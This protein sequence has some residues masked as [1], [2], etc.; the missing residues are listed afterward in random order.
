MVEVEV[1]QEV[2]EEVEARVGRGCAAPPTSRH[3]TSLHATPFHSSR[4]FPP[5]D[6]D[7]EYSLFR[8]AMSA[9]ARVGTVA[10]PA[11]K[12]VARAFLKLG[13]WRWALADD[14]DDATLADVLG[15]FR[16]ATDACRQWAKAWHHWALFNAAAME[17]YT[18]ISPAAATRHVAPAI[19][20]FFRSIALGGSAPQKRKGGPLQDILRL[21]TLWFNHGAA[22]EVEAALMEGFGHV[23]IDTWLAVI[24]QIVARI[25]SNSP[26]V[27]ALIHQLLVRIGRQHPQALLYP[28]L[29]ACKSQSTSRRSAA[30]VVLD[31]LR[32]H[33]ALLVEQAQVVSLE[34]IRVAILWHEAWHEAL[35]EASQLYFGEQNVDGMLRVLAPLHHIIERLG[36]ETLHEISFVQA[37]GRELQ[38]AN[39]WCQKYRETGREEELNQAW[40]LYYHV[41]KRINKQLPTLTTLELQYVSPRLLNAQG[42]ELCVPGNYMPGVPGGSVTI[43]AFAPTMHVIT[44][45]Q[46]P[47][48]L[49]IHG[50]DGKDYGYLL[51]GHEDLRQDERVMQLF[52]LVNMLLNS[53]PATATRDLS[54]ARYAVVP[55][56][57]NSGLI[58]WVPNCDT[59]HALIREHRDAHKVPLNLEHR[60]M[61]AMAP[62]YDH[63]PLVNKVRE[64]SRARRRRETRAR[65]D[66]QIRARVSRPRVGEAMMIR[67]THIL[68]NRRGLPPRRR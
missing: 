30:M 44:S 49:Q 21:L 11:P 38:E 26:P 33:S 55:L 5:T 50:S 17:H 45:K 40:D 19:S 27:R 64:K 12:L 18:K 2:F 3:A 52:G 41:F 59:L 23:S 15:A 37:Y 6:R 36:A 56:S 8:R 53:T 24:P 20:G 9:A 4:L 1:F 43:A 47:R 60:L 51:K 65:I 29:V 25:H 42:L 67:S 31:N 35:E 32:Q 28:L 68:L 10:A 46:R 14:M 34:L 54:I 61:L 66:V 58:G 13:Q 57:P 16:T 39:E 63:L 22:P 48:R 7:C 62:D